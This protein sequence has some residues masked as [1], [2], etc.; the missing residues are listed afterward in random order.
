MDYIIINQRK[1]LIFKII[2]QHGKQLFLG[3]FCVIKS[4]PYVMQRLMSLLCGLELIYD[5]CF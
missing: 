3:L 1:T 2:V 5:L 4:N